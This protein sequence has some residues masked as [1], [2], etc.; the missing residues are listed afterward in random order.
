MSLH[1][2][3]QVY[4]VDEKQQ[5]D[6]NQAFLG[7][8]GRGRGQSGGRGQSRGRSWNSFS[9][10]QPNNNNNQS[11]N[12]QPQLKFNNTNN[13]KGEGPSKPTHKKEACQICG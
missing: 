2:H 9:Q 3:E 4:L 1:N 10:N 13:W 11:S 5:L 12:F 6:H 8:R 7:Q